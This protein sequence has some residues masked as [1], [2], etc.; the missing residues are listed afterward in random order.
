MEVRRSRGEDD[1]G[2]RGI[3]ADSGALSPE[4]HA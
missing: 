1:A 2:G 3:M 4:E